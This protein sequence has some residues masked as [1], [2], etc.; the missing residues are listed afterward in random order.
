MKQMDARE[1]RL[2][3]IRLQRIT[4][5]YTRPETRRKTAKAR[6]VQASIR[7]GALLEREER[8]ARGI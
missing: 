3:I 7:L 1:L 5:D 6:Q 4:R 2:E 8:E